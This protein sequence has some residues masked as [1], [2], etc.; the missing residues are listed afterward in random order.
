[1]NSENTVGNK[2][3]RENFSEQTNTIPE[4][5]SVNPERANPQVHTES[6]PLQS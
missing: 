2:T 6:L 5:D 4:G 3:F 1:M